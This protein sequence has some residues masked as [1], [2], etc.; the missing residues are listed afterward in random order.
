MAARSIP[1]TKDLDSEAFAQAPFTART[2]QDIQDR[3]ALID[4]IGR[5]SDSLFKFGSFGIGLDGIL[6]WIPG[7]GE[8]YSLGAGAVLLFEGYRA[9]V[10]TLVLIQVAAIVALRTAIDLGNFVPL[11][12]IGSSLIVDLFRGHRLAARM[13][14]RAIDE[15]LYLEGPPDP[16]SP[17]YLEAITRIR[18]GGDK[19]RVVFLG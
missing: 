11:A 2:P 5:L 13:L 1:I 19:K 10:P 7:L 9:R 15:T 6:A 17:A 16:A 12:G 3:R 4:L 18:R 8:I 14:I